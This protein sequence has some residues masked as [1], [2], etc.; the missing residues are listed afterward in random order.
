MKLI[1]LIKASVTEKCL[2]W[3]LYGPAET[4]IGSTLYPVDSTHLI[5]SYIAIV[6]PLNP[7]RVSDTFNLNKTDSKKEME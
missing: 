6:I 3:N 5:L 1:N 4:T 2:I 7:L